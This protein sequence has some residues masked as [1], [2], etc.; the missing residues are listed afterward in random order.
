[1]K[2]IYLDT[3]K[4]AI[5]VLILTLEVNRNGKVYSKDIDLSGNATGAAHWGAQTVVDALNEI[6]RDNVQQ[7]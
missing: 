4:K 7:R 3:K 1:M 6:E 5:E 2:S